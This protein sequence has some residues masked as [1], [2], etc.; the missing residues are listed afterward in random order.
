M[1]CKYC[2]TQLSDNAR[3]CSACGKSLIEVEESPKVIVEAEES[4]VAE[5]IEHTVMEEATEEE[6]SKAVESEITAQEPSEPKKKKGKIIVPIIIAA[7]ILAIGAVACFFLFLK[8]DKQQ[9]EYIYAY[10][11]NDGNAYVC[12]DNGKKLKIGSGIEEAIM[13]PDCK[14][15]VV[16]EEEGRIYWTDARLSE[17]HVIFK[18]N[19][20][21]KLEVDAEVEELTNK[22][23]LI[24]YGEYN[25][26]TDYEAEK[27]YRYEFAS[28]KNL[29]MFEWSEKNGKE[30]GPD[31]CDMNYPEISEDLHV[32]YA[33]DNEIR[34]L[35]ADSNKA[36]KIADYAKDIDISI[37][38]VS[39]DGKTVAWKEVNNGKYYLKV[40]IDGNQKTVIEEKGEQKKITEDNLD[41]KFEQYISETYNSSKYDTEEDYQTAILTEWITDIFEFYGEDASEDEIN[42]YVIKKL[43]KYFVNDV[44]VPS[45]SMSGGVDGISII[46]GG[47]YSVYIKDGK[48]KTV[49]FDNEVNGY[50]VYTS[51]GIILERDEKASSAQGYYVNVNSSKDEDGYNLYYV[52]FKNGEKTKLLS[53]VES[54][55]VNED[56]IIYTD[57]NS[58]LKIGF[59]DLKKGDLKDS[60][61]VAS[62]IYS[63]KMAQGNTRYLYYTKERTDN[64]ESKYDLYVYDIKEEES[65]K[66]ESNVASGVR[67][68]VDGNS[69]YYF[70]DITSDKD[71]Y[72][73]YGELYVYNAKKDE[74]QKIS[75]DVG[76]YSLTS[77]L[78][79]GYID[80]DSFFFDKYKGNHEASKDNKNEVIDVCYYGGKEIEVLL[81]DFET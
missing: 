25:E 69:I 32:A 64:E 2:G 77:N 53:K 27:Y 42:E 10:V 40:W 45:F 11:D 4:P 36:V 20:D 66:I 14:K 6:I 56:I 70:K 43:E 54:F 46:N 17:K 26:D 60:V 12:Y 33:Q 65:K 23:V 3:F 63:S 61:K 35:A 62:D 73:Y 47:K 29:L 81:K 80:P 34:L 13:T 18:A 72:Y 71:S 44:T 68:S 30:T 58:S 5:E 21:T 37:I 24:D 15:I 75:S 28:K 8:P 31:S 16:V 78:N 48:I 52:D 51:N 22:F 1:F 38:G 9:P 76:I 19:E 49:K 79:T 59:V 39:N 74:A 55:R 7:L 67:V 41:E 57:E 50:N